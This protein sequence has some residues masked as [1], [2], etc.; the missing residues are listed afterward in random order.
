MEYFLFNGVAKY[1][2]ASPRARKMSLFSSIIIMNILSYAIIRI[3]LLL[4]Y[5]N[6]YKK[7]AFDFLKRNSYTNVCMKFLC[8][9]KLITPLL[10]RHSIFLKEM[11]IFKT[12]SAD[13][14]DATDL[15]DSADSADSADLDF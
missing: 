1:T 3:C 11:A 8:D 14:A 4:P 12:D 2:T 10:N 9:P 5:S 15:A 13:S 6:F 7:Q